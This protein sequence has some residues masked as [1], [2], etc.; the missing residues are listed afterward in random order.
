[1]ELR[2]LG[3][4]NYFQK[5]F[6]Q[7]DKG[8]LAP[9]RVA[10][11]HKN[12]YKV[13]TEHGELLAN[14]SGRLNYNAVGRI[15]YPAVGDWVILEPRFEENRAT[16]HA[17]LERKS[18]FTRKQ[19]GNKVDEQIVAAN[20]DTVFIVTSLNEE[21]NIR[22]LERYLTQVWNS[23][24]N[25][26]IILNKADLCKNITEK[27]SEVNN[28]AFGIPVHVVSCLDV[29][30]LEGLDGYLREGQTIALIGS[31]GVGK[32]SLINVLIGEQIQ[33]TSEIRD[34]DKGRHTTTHRELIKLPQG[35][36]LIDT[37][38]MRE[39]QLWDDGEGVNET[40]ADIEELASQCKFRDCKHDA[41]PG[42]AVKKA[43]EEGKLAPER[44]K[45]YRKMLREVLYQEL[46]MSNSNMD[47]ARY[48]FKDIKKTRTKK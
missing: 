8:N 23:G 7:Y 20:I 44:L 40:F 34:D 38:G 10:I 29:T 45:S 9:G 22:R 16:I 35:G 37:P 15:D 2:K 14:I 18:K 17:I 13:L 47:I 48:K 11:E 33:K 12:M 21:F 28:I 25:P 32:S 24:A 6:I 19:A 3:W 43:L 27:M 46:K 1:M 31:S 4:D 30:G 5:L 26:V 42:C 36:V 39:L 41:E